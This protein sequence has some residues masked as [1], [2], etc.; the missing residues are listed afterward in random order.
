MS[1]SSKLQQLGRIL[2]RHPRNACVVEPFL[3]QESDE[4]GKSFD[5]RRI[6]CLTKIS[7]DHRRLRSN[8]PNHLCERSERERTSSIGRRDKAPLKEHLIAISE[9]FLH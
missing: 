5:R 2:A 4:R 3:V 1:P 7:R 6:A 9:F 8:S